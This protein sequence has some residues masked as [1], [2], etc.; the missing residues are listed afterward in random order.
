MQ[1]GKAY[2][3]TAEWALWRQRA[4][5]IPGLLEYR[6]FESHIY[7]LQWKVSLA[8]VIAPGALFVDLKHLD[9]TFIDNNMCLIMLNCLIHFIAYV[10]LIYFYL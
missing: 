6:D 8:V 7:L 3:F 9:T 1:E 2:P 10:A 4:S 5:M